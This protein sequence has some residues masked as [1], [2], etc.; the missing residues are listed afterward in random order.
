MKP[1]KLTQM[2][3]I[4][5]PGRPEGA[6][7]ELPSFK[8]PHRLGGVDEEISRAVLSTGLQNQ[9]LIL[10]LPVQFSA[11]LPPSIPLC[12]HKNNTET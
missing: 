1:V 4:E 5:G 9:L 8:A 12:V 10:N 3:Q 7:W 6:G 2:P 11:S